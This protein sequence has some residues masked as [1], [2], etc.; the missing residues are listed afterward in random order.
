[1][2]GDVV[3]VGDVLA[4]LDPTDY[5][6]SVD[7]IYN[8]IADTE[9]QQKALLSQDAKRLQDAKN[10]KIIDLDQ[11]QHD[12]DVAQVNLNDAIIDLETSAHQAADAAL[13]I[14]TAADED[15]LYAAARL[16]AVRVSYIESPTIANKSTYD[17]AYDDYK[18]TWD[19][20]KEAIWSDEW[21]T[22][23]DKAFNAGY[24]TIDVAKI[25]LDAAITAH[26]N[27]VRSNDLAIQESAYTQFNH[28][29]QNP[30]QALA[31]QLKT[32][33]RLLA[34]TTVL[35]PCDGTITEVYAKQGDYPTGQLF[36]IENINSLEI[37][38]TVAE[39][40]IAQIEFGQVVHFT[41]EATGS[42]DLSGTVTQI[43]PKAINSDGDFTVI[44]L[45]DSPDS[46]LR[47]GMNA[48]LTIVL[49]S[50]AS[51]YSVPF[52][53]VTLDD[54]GETVVVALGTDGVTRTNIS[55]T[56]GLKT[57]NLVEI[58]GPGLVDGIT[59]LNDPE[60]RNNA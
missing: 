43:S 47:L 24:E 39:Y 55:V 1:K 37:S 8:L 10:Q 59:I 4:R 12:I 25:T 58:A 15:V 7:D 27:Y 57:D 9:A 2:T 32:A 6:Q 21:Q 13:D 51:A 16:A 53:A 11:R 31:S 49:A 41:T 38:T 44:V 26:F 42:D 22:A 50:K 60:G 28:N 35:A 54:Q 30:A 5:Q 3:N 40:D 20:Q 14:R 56:L 33:K 23:Y 52:N 19:N 46:R 18:A 17:E 29:L 36:A 48:K 45:I 34:E